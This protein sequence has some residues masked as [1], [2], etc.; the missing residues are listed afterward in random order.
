MAVEQSPQMFSQMD[1]ETLMCFWY[2]KKGSFKL[3]IN[4]CKISASDKRK[5]LR[6]QD[7]LKFIISLTLGNK[8]AMRKINSKIESKCMTHF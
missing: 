3:I 2:I 5:I 7:I 4:L 6:K 8:F 1:K